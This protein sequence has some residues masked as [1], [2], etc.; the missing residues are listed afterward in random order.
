MPLLRKR[1]KK[2]DWVRHEW[3]VDREHKGVEIRKQWS[4][5][6]KLVWIGNVGFCVELNLEIV[7]LSVP[8]VPIQKYLLSKLEF[9]F[10]EWKK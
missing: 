8:L 10:C 5:I 6:C 2:L 7:S 9:K 1:G 4:Y 3:T